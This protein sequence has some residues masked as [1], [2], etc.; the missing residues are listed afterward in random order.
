MFEMASTPL[1]NYEMQIKNTMKYYFTLTRL[2]KIKSSAPTKYW[3]K[4]VAMKILTD[5][6]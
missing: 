1:S 5:G 3:Q 4:Y 2:A 6:W